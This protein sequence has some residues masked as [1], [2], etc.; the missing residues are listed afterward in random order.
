MHLP[1]KGLRA[2]GI[3]ESYTGSTTSTLAG[4]VMRK[5]LRIDG[6][7][8]GTVTVGGMDATE[9]I[10]GMVN[11]LQRKDLNVILLSGCVIAW[12]NVIDPGRIAEVTGVPAIC[13]TYEESD[14][15]AED[16][17]HHFP[18]DEL[19]LLAYQDL[20]NRNPVR[21]HTGQSIYLRSW[22]ITADDAARLC[23]DFTHEGGIPEPLRVA[24]L[25][26]RSCSFSRFT[27]PDAGYHLP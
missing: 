4:I 24:R 11:R 7:C 27:E 16:I 5:D 6:F 10:I 20:G 26:A 2:L 25:C 15:L 19:R 21:L 14:G 1:K 12:F 9:A 17:R 3:A 23:N 18:H 13:V 8:F 22:G